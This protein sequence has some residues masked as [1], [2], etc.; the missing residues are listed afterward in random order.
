MVWGAV[1]QSNYGVVRAL[2]FPIDSTSLLAPVTLAGGNP[3]FPE[4]AASQ[5]VVAVDPRGGAVAVWRR[6]GDRIRSAQLGP[7]SSSWGGPSLDQA[8]DGDGLDVAADP[9]GNAVVAWTQFP[10]LSSRQPGDPSLTLRVS[11]AGYDAAGPVLSMSAK[12]TRTVMIRS[13]SGELG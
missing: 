5:P 8:I 6:G 7:D 9:A 3:V 12:T 1:N 10:S 13:A 4:P 11:A 2:T